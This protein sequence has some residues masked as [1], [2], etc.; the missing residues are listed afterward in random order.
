MGFVAEGGRLFVFGG[1]A[2]HGIQHSYFRAGP[3]LTGF[4]PNTDLALGDFFQF[5]I[6]TLTW[7]ELGGGLATGSPPS[8]RTGFGFVA[9]GSKLF[10][11]GGSTSG[12][13]F[14]GIVHTK[15]LLLSLAS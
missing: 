9:G 7:T 3:D 5:D 14:L 6:A 8:A 10:V 13:A 2:D 12:T 4:Y 15:P 1:T 11:Y